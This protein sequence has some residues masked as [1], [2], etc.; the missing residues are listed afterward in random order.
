MCLSEFHMVSIR[1]IWHNKKWRKKIGKRSQKL[2]SILDSIDNSRHCLLSLI[3]IYHYMAYVLYMKCVFGFIFFL[4]HTFQFGGEIKRIRNVETN[5]V[6]VI[7]SMSKKYEAYFLEF[8]STDALFVHSKWF[9]TIT[10]DI[11]YGI[12]ILCAHAINHRTNEKWVRLHEGIRIWL[13]LGV[14]LEL[15]LSLS[16]AQ[17]ANSYNK[18]MAVVV[19]RMNRILEKVFFYRESLE[20]I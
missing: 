3:I 16:S 14:I 20:P 6:N 19:Y 17:S 12:D 11:I 2:P 13:L 5:N 18:S 8:H 15:L 4:F 7:G 9:T 1:P 10:W